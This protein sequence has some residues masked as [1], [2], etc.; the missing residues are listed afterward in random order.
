MS[1]WA[2]EMDPFL[3]NCMR[4]RK[5]YIVKNIVIGK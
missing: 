4:A 3:T 2:L 5:S 1:K